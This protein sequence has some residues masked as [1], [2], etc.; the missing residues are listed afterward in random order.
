MINKVIP[1]VSVGDFVFGKHRDIIIDTFGKPTG[2]GS[3]GTQDFYDNFGLTLYYSES[4]RL[5]QVIYDNPNDNDF[6][7]FGKKL[8][9]SST[10]KLFSTL[11]EHENDFKNYDHIETMLISEK[12]GIVLVLDI[13]DDEIEEGEVEDNILSNDYQV[14]SIAFYDGHWY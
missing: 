13:D 11:I 2:N 8:N 5:S 10:L 7:L 6:S 3:D 4:G 12:L 9:T 14:T 1:K